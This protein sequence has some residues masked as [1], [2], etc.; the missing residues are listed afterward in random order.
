MNAEITSNVSKEMRH[1][2]TVVGTEIVQLTDVVDRAYRGVLIV[3]DPTNAGIVY[4]GG[5]AVTADATATGGIPLSAEKSI[6]VPIANPKQLYV[7]ADTADQGVAW[8][9]L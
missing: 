1:G 8:M 2:H 5:K 9:A 7:I 3:A 4:V 6:F